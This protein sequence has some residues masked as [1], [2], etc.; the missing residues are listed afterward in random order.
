VDGRNHV[1]GRSHTVD[2]S[3]DTLL[4]DILSGGLRVGSRVA[5]VGSIRLGRSG[6]MDGRNHVVGLHHAVN[7]GVNT[8]LTNILM[9]SLVLMSMLVMVSV[10]VVLDEALVSRRVA[11]VGSE[12]LLRL[13]V[14][15][16]VHVGVLV[17]E[18]THILVV[19]F[20]ANIGFL[21]EARVGGGVAAVGSERS[22]LS[23]ERSGMHAGILVD[24]V[25]DGL[26]VAS[27]A[28]VGLLGEHLGVSGSPHA[29]LLIVEDGLLLSVESSSV[30]VGE[31]I[32]G[33]RSGEIDLRLE[34]VNLIGT[35]CNHSD[36]LGG[37]SL[38]LL[39]GRSRRQQQCNDCGRLLVHLIN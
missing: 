16:G 29:S 34:H 9:S 20:F 26:V 37:L 3:V 39:H 21:R 13:G 27:S 31:G 36:T 11:T 22:L 33:V 8:L 17:H 10:G 30:R 35:T 4:A 14:R 12:R 19:T 32:L 5:T 28:D 2:L 24:E 6:V 25:A 15:S 38:L 1:V 7:L 18:M 23:G